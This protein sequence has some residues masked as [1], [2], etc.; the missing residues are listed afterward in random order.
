MN[1]KEDV[2][3]SSLGFVRSRGSYE[4]LYLLRQQRK[5][6]I[7]SSERVPYS[8]RNGTGIECRGRMVLMRCV[9][10]VGCLHQRF[11]VRK[12]ALS[13]P[14]FTGGFSFPIPVSD[15]RALGSPAYRSPRPPHMFSDPQSYVG[16]SVQGTCSFELQDSDICRDNGFTSMTVDVAV[17]VS[18]YYILVVFRVCRSRFHAHSSRGSVAPLS[19]AAIS[20]FGYD[21]FRLPISMNAYARG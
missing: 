8:H 1:G 12:P 11:G 7:L 13:R 6:A 3:G 21:C 4:E 20:P 19:A 18:V 14:P 15:R 2:P 16:A 10:P 17:D 9:L 5:C